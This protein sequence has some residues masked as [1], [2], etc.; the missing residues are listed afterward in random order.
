MWVSTDTE[1]VKLDADDGTE[2]W[3]TD[4]GGLCLALDNDAGQVFGVGEVFTFGSAPF[5]KGCGIKLDTDGTILGV[6]GGADEHEGF[7]SYPGRAIVVG[8]GAVYVG[9]EQW[10][11][12][13]NTAG[14]DDFV[15][16]RSGRVAR[17][18]SDD[19]QLTW[20]A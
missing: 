4:V 5:D 3:R 19:L 17:W 8:D 2:L 18:N 16:Y 12:D 10:T 7:G 13:V 6:F 1:I 9:G 14:A 20:L 15:A 11:V